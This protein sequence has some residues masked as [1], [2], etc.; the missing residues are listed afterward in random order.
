MKSITQVYLQP[1]RLKNT[2][3]CKNK[4]TVPC[5]LLEVKFCVDRVWHE[6]LFLLAARQTLFITIESCYV[7][8]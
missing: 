7:T 8:H 6:F 2:N 1:I 3:N 4:Q 5:I